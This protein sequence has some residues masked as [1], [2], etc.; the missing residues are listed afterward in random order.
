MVL[1]F[2]LAACATKDAYKLGQ[3]E[4]KQGNLDMAVIHYMRAAREEPNNIE[5]RI[6]LHRSMVEAANAHVKEANKNVAAQQLEDAVSEFETA[7]QL[8]PSNAF[9]RDKLA[10]T[11]KQIQENEARLREAEEFVE[12]RARARE[13]LSTQPVLEPS[14]NAPINLKFAQDTSL[15]KIFEVLSKLSG[16]N[17]LFDN[18]FRDARVTVDLVDVTFKEALDKMVLINRLF[19]KVVDPSTIIIIPD[20]A[21]KHR[22]YDDLVLKTFF[23]TNAEVNTI[24]NMLRTIAG[25][26]RVQPNPELKSITLRATPDQVMVAERIIQLNDKTKSEVILDIEFLEVNRNRALDFGL[27]LS[28]YTAGIGFQPAGAETAGDEGGSGTTVTRLNR[29]AAGDSSDWV[30]SFPSAAFYTLFKQ[31]SEARVLSAPRIR[32][33]EGQAAELLLGEEIPVPVTTFVSQVGT[34]LANT[35]VTSFQYRN[36]GINVRITPRVFVDGT[37]ELELSLE[38]SVLGEDRQISPGQSAPVFRARSI[39]NVVRL[40]DGETNLI[41]GL[42]D[43]RDREEV[44]GIPGLTDIPILNKLFAKNEEESFEAEVVFS[45]T[46]HIVRAPVV[47]QEDLQSLPM[48]TEQRIQVPSERPSPFQPPPEPSVEPPPQPVEPTREAP[49]VATPEPAELEPQAVEPESPPTPEPAE[50]EPEIVEPEPPP[51]PQPESETPEATPPVGPIS[52]LMSPPSVIAAAGDRV[53]MTLIA[54]GADGLSSG[55]IQITFDAQAIEA[56]DVQQGPFLSIDGKQV[57]FAPVIEPGRVSIRFSRQND[58]LGLHGSGHL[59]RLVLVVKEPGPALVINATGS[60]RDA[61]GE[62]IPA[63]FTSARIE[64]Q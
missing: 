33:V 37:I 5:Y 14:S 64:T 17:I 57:V 24:A 44:S 13:L 15:K 8:D 11:R 46:P 42:I 21:Q 22:Q 34:G 12:R 35:P 39:S 48:G 63:E 59:V 18:N 61:G 19:Y 45:V 29:L 1:I 32:G 47:T 7:L 53:E 56:V 54:G 49:P 38:T 10:A 16:V 26:Q 40:R 28:S 23:I 2:G 20:N 30:L 58:L 55:D 41:G 3:K 62:A 51:A 9:A 52:V 43:A 4:E 6:A 36:V 25:I 50:L 60:L 31:K 27:E